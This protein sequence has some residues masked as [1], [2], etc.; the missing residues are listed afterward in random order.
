MASDD[1][2]VEV[3]RTEVVVHHI[4]QSHTYRFPILG[5]RSLGLRGTIIEPNPKA[6]REARGYLIEAYATAR[7]ALAG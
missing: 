4:R 6:K 2:E 3:F 7:A 1:F 5:Q